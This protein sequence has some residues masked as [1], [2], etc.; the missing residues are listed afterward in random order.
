MTR[1]CL[2]VV[3][4]AILS[5]AAAGQVADST[6]HPRYAEA[7]TFASAWLNLV[8]AGDAEASFAQLAPT[9]QGNLTPAEWREVIT[10][11]RRDLGK[12]V[13]RTL[14]R[15][16]WYDNP[17]NAP[18]PGLYA[19]VEYDSVFENADKHFQYV[20]LHSQNR[21]PFRVMRNE[22]TFALN[23]NDAAK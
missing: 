23:R 14:R 5:F 4:T 6:S 19:A 18:L 12:R 9:F 16:V 11:T 3:A 21:A 15:V 1:R 10:R 22:A 20:I 17:P 2:I 13:S 7:I 8:E